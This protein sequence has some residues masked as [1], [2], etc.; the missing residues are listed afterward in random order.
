MRWE[1]CTYEQ[2]GQDVG[3]LLRDWINVDRIDADFLRESQD[4][5]FHSRTSFLD[6]L[7]SIHTD[8]DS[9]DRLDILRR[10][11]EMLDLTGKHIHK[12][13]ESTVGQSLLD[14]ALKNDIDWQFSCTRGTCARCRCLVTAG[15]ALLSDVSDEEWDRLDDD[16]LDQ[17][18]RL[19]CQAIIK[20]RGPITA[21]NQTYF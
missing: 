10:L 7:S 18:Y 19:G 14:V 20:E 16:E 1:Q 5:R 21:V 2:Y 17:G 11:L 6:R 3:I 4:D 9:N 12:Q 15:M 13:V 8:L